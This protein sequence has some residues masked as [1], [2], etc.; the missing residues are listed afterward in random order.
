MDHA[1]YTQVNELISIMLGK[2]DSNFDQATLYK[3]FIGL[4]LE[5]NI[6]T[7]LEIR[8]RLIAEGKIS[9]KTAAVIEGAKVFAPDAGKY[10]PSLAMEYNDHRFVTVL[11]LSNNPSEFDPKFEKAMAEIFGRAF[12]E[13][14]ARIEHENQHPR[15]TQITVIGYGFD[16]S[17]DSGNLESVL[18]RHMAG[19][20][21]LRRLFKASR[22]IGPM[23]GE[24]RD[25]LFGHYDLNDIEAWRHY[26]PLL[27]RTIDGLGLAGKR[28]AVAAQMD[29]RAWQ[30]HEEFKESTAAE[31]LGLLIAKADGYLP[32]AHAFDIVQQVESV[33]MSTSLQRRFDQLLELYSM[34]REGGFTSIN[35][36]FDFND[37]DDFLYVVD[38]REHQEILLYRDQNVRFAAALQ[39]DATGEP[40]ELSVYAIRRPAGDDDHDGLNDRMIEA[41]KSGSDQ[42]LLARFRISAGKL[43]LSTAPS[44]LQED[45]RSWNG[46]TFGVETSHC[47]LE[48]ELQK[49]QHSSARP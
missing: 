36:E 42:D 44:P 38:G 11:D 15:V 17:L 3:I 49:R 20:F 21:D 48:E 29:T 2:R 43:E 19:Q 34:A 4:S 24:D 26:F 14:Q 45:I 46:F 18:E 16:N 10:H 9:A 40:S 8:K 7:V 39:K 6:E 27:Q 41:A 31:K 25:W 33:R 5:A 35:E 28:A 13:E 30:H 47:C 37:L 23:D 22:S 12:N 1:L 32:G